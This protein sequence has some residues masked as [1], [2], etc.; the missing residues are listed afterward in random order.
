MVNLITA[1]FLTNSFVAFAAKPV[2]KLSLKVFKWYLPQIAD[3][4]K[5]CP[6][7]FANRLF[8]KK[9]ITR[10]TWHKVLHTQALAPYDKA[11]IL[12]S[13]VEGTIATSKDDKALKKFCGALSKVGNLRR[14]S[15]RIMKRYG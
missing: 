12:L 4:V 13:A 1:F 14:L 9:L 7:S 10:E 3:A 8:S 15:Q 5:E 2:E 6:E 11:S